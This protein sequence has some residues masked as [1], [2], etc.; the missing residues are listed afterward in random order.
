MTAGTFG[1]GVSQAL[2]EPGRVIGFITSGKGGSTE[3]SVSVGG[4]WGG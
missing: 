3:F 2:R 4:P 1:N